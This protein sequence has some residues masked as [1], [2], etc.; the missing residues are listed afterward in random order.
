MSDLFKCPDKTTID[1]L[2]AEGFSE[3]IIERFFM[4][5][6][7]GITLDPEIEVSSGVFQYIFRIYHPLL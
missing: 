6:F 1:F 3:K 5:F 4:P 2:R 7:K